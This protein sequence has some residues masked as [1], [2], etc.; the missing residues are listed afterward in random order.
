MNIFSRP[1]YRRALKHLSAEELILI[2]NAIARLAE[3]MGKPHVHSGLSIRK[4]LPA[5]FEMRVG[6]QTR[7]LFARESGDLVLVFVGDHAQVRAW[8]KENA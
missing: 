5:I 1:F 2:N 6:L 3:A 8:L 7:V 4:L